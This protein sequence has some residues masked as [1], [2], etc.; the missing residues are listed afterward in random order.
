MTKRR[1]TPGEEPVRETWLIDG[2]KGRTIVVVPYRQDWPE[3]FR[4]HR[5]RI[6]AAIGAGALGIDHIGSTAVP[7]LAEKPIV[8]ILV[9]VAD[10]ADEGAYL[11]AMQCSGY[12]LRVREPDFE[13]HR[14][15]RTPMLDVH[16]HV[17]SVGSPEIER[18]LRF[19]DA[20]RAAPFLRARYQTLKLTLAAQDWQD[21][22][23]YAQAKSEV[24]EAIIHW[25][26]RTDRRGPQLA[27]GGG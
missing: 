27:P 19:R 18:Y 21:M 12:V 17:L 24:V 3:T 20:L 13:E 8:D 2:V 15:F 4:L 6:A 9:V 7:G 25:S 16:V 10:S 14:M 23:A 5:E 1:D 26:M 22:N 11:P